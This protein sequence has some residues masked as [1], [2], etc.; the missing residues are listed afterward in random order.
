LTSSQKSFTLFIVGAGIS[1]CQH[2]FQIQTHLKA[3]RMFL[4]LA[5]TVAD[6]QTQ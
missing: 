3:A 1:G 4:E 2:L 5:V 6:N